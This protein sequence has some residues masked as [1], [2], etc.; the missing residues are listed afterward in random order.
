[1]LEHRYDNGTGAMKFGL[2]GGAT[3]SAPDRSGDTGSGDSQG[4]RRYVEYVI[5]AERL[6]FDS[7]FVVEH[8]FTGF[9]QVS[10]VLNLL[11]YLAAQTT[12]IR[13]GTAV[14]VLPWHNPILL[15]EQ[16][17]TVDVLSGGR[18]DLG[19]GRGYRPNEYH[20]FGVDPDEADDRYQECLDILQ[21]GW[22]ANDRFSH[23]G[24]FWSYRDIVIEPTPVQRPHPPIWTGAGSERSV[25]Q[26]ARAGHRLLVDQFGTIDMTCQRVDWYRDEIERSGETFD[27]SHVAAARGLM[28]M[29]DHSADEVAQ[30]FQ[31]RLAGIVRLREASKIPG[32]DRRLTVEDHA[33]YDDTRQSSEAAVIGVTTEETIRRLKTLESAGVGQ[34]LFTAGGGVDRLRL[35]AELVMPAF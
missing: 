15:A 26:A 14:V 19:V 27:P 16:A 2:F 5:E 34:V 28:L 23:E 7:A 24:R 8:H 22:T 6:G 20:G 29:P 3:R 35:F 31:N 17:S 12:T 1:M 11:A 18:L 32:D 25:R 10:A 4:Y 9:G 33:F 30:E 13:L 21:K